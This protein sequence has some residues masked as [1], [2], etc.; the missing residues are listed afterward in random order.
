MT[1]DQV[2]LGVIA[3]EGAVIAFSTVKGGIKP[4]PGG[5]TTTAGATTPTP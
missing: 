2:L 5:T 3:A 1:A 4:K